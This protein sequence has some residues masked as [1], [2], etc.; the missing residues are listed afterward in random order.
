MNLILA[1]AKKHLYDLVVIPF[2]CV[3]NTTYYSN[4]LHQYLCSYLDSFLWQ[5]NI[6]ITTCTYM[7]WDLE[8]AKSFLKSIFATY[9]HI[10]IL[11]KIKYFILNDISS[12]TSFLHLIYFIFFKLLRIIWALFNKI[13]INT[14]I[15]YVKFI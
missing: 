9:Y 15:Y 1:L 4:E 5:G 6:Y 7:R 10:E 3:L 8:I 11:E 12:I 2:F 14:H 13:P